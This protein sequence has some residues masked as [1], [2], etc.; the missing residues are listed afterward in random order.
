MLLQIQWRWLF[1]GLRSR[2]NVESTTLCQS[3]FND[4]AMIDLA[5][6]T[7]MYEDTIVNA[8]VI[9]NPTSNQLVVARSCDQVVSQNNTSS[10]QQGAFKNHDRYRGRFSLRFDDE[11]CKEYLLQQ[12]Q[13]PIPKDIKRPVYKKIQ[14]T[15]R[16]LICFSIKTY[17]KPLV[18]QLYLWNPVIGISKTLPN[19]LIPYGDPIFRPR[20]VGIAFGYFL[21]AND[22]KVVKIEKLFAAREEAPTTFVYV[23]IYSL[24]SN[25]WKT[26]RKPEFSQ[27]SGYELYNSIV[28]NGVPYWVWNKNPRHLIVCFDM[29]NESFREIVLPGQYSTDQIISINLVQQFGK[30]AVF[31]F[32]YK[33]TFILDIFVL[34]KGVEMNKVWTKK[35]TLDLDKIGESWWPIGFKNNGEIV[36]I[37]YKFGEGGFLSYDHEKEEETEMVDNS[38]DL[39]SYADFED[40]CN[41]F[42]EYGYS[43][44]FEYSTDVIQ[45]M[46]VD[47]F[48]EKLVLL[49]HIE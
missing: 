45:P 2:F 28:V 16:G 34:E 30:L 15:S 35:V 11:Q 27:C 36:L 39:W 17:E 42:R 47:Y 25:S 1:R 23:Y 31:L 14:G 49:G 5:I 44:P 43:G 18:Y 24:S 20:V 26:I 37:N 12:Q 40:P 8:V 10:L 48:E 41:P 3:R 32:Y 21:N 7:A 29:E 13:L 46:Y 6:T 4:F 33:D 19:T 38:G 22:Y 9:A